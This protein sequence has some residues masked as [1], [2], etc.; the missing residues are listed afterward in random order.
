MVRAGVRV[1]LWWSGAEGWW[2]TAH[3]VVPDSCPCAVGA[4]VFPCIAFGVRQAAG[5]SRCCALLAA[6]TGGESREAVVCGGA[7]ARRHV[8]VCMCAL[9]LCG[10]SMLL[11]GD[12]CFRGTGW[13]CGAAGLL[14]VQFGISVA[15]RR[16]D[17]RR[18]PPRGTGGATSLVGCACGPGLPGPPGARARCGPRCVGVR[19]DTG[20]RDVVRAGLRLRVALGSNLQFLP[21]RKYREENLNWLSRSPSH[22]PLFPYIPIN[23]YLSI[24]QLPH[25]SASHTA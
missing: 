25:D 13:F 6:Y 3:T 11:A 7:R 16:P 4:D 15:S 20:G 23:T 2:R 24:Q 14:R 1:V 18:T 22:P 9:V 8:C 21:S 12:P 19:G 10:R 17:G 5:E